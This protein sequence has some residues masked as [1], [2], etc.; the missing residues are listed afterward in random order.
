MQ[1]VVKQECVELVS[2]LLYNDLIVLRLVRRDKPRVYIASNST[3][4]DLAKTKIIRGVTFRVLQISDVLYPLYAPTLVRK[5]LSVETLI[6]F[7]KELHV[8]YQKDDLG[9]YI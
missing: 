8:E 4:F 9:Y 2:D 5:H 3:L 1:E 6:H 7:F